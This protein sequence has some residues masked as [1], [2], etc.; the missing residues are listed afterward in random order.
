MG[1]I[2]DLLQTPRPLVMGILNATPDSFSGDGLYHHDDP[3]ATGMSQAEA[4]IAGGADILDIGGESTRPG[5]LP[6]AAE[7]EITRIVPLIKAVRHAHPACPISIDTRHAKTAAAA[8]AAG[9]TI[10]NDIS[11]L[12]DPLMAK[13]VADYKCPIILMH[14]RARQNDVENHALIGKSYAAGNYVHFLDDL[15]KDMMDLAQKAI[16]AGIKENHI[17][18][19][20]GL[21]F[22]KSVAQN[23]AIL[24]NIPRLAKLGYP[25]LIGASR[26]SFVGHTINRPPHERLAGSLAAATL[27]AFLGG[28]ILRV[29]DV[30]E[31]V[32]TLRLTEAVMK[33]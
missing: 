14:N 26:K 19:D 18:L 21:G 11:G 8:M 1:P 3:V 9:A 16:A 24:K 4:M 25:L 17:I 7:E 20:P 13:I 22:G 2:R 32:D 15:Q 33:A 5:A 10:I 30:R 23:L 12:G 28:K 6:V 29:H 27:A 31:T